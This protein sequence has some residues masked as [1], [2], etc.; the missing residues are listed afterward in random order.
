MKTPGQQSHETSLL[1]SLVKDGGH[2]GVVSIP[3]MDQLAQQQQQQQHQQT[4][5]AFS[6]SSMTSPVPSSS[7]L[8]NQSATQSQQQS[9]LDRSF[10]T[11]LIC[12][13]L[14]QLESAT[15]ISTHYQHSCDRLIKL[16]KLEC[17]LS[18]E[19][20]ALLHQRIHGASDLSISPQSLSKSS[21]SK[22]KSSSS[23]S[24]ASQ[25]NAT[26]QKKEVLAACN[27]MLEEEFNIELEDEM[28]LMKPSNEPIMNDM[29]E[30]EE[31]EE[32]ERREE[33]SPIKATREEGG[34]IIDEEGDQQIS[35][36]ANEA[37]ENDFISPLSESLLRRRAEIEDQIDAMDLQMDISVMLSINENANHFHPSPSPVQAVAQPQQADFHAANISAISSTHPDDDTY[38]GEERDNSTIA[39]NC[40]TFT[41]EP[42]HHPHVNQPVPTAVT[43]SRT[44]SSARGVLLLQEPASPLKSSPAPRVVVPEEADEP[45]AAAITIGCSP[46][47]ARSNSSSL[48]IDPYEVDAEDDEELVGILSELISTGCALHE[49]D[50]EDAVED[51]G[52]PQDDNMG[53]EEADQIIQ[54]KT[55]MND[56]EM[57]AALEFIH[58]SQEIDRDHVHDDDDHNDDGQMIK[59]RST[60]DIIQFFNNKI[61]SEF[62]RTS[63]IS[64]QSSSSFRMKAATTEEE[65]EIYQAKTPKKRGGLQEHQATSLSFS[66]PQ[67]GSELKNKTQ[68]LYS[69]KQL[70]PV[71][72]TKTGGGRGG[73][74]DENQLNYVSPQKQ[75]FHQKL[76]K[77]E[78]LTNPSLSLTAS[79]IKQKERE[80]QAAAS[81]K[82]VEIKFFG[83]QRVVVRKNSMF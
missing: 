82:N 80:A 2:G 35:P 3:S 7:Q 6:S 9:N 27:L 19:E 4:I 11:Q 62:K 61:Q 76:Q 44:S 58:P 69:L 56:Q 25:T 28:I 55:T 40:S 14:E 45:P 75:S 31:D 12:K 57:L 32:E 48:F 81:D 18:P 38:K 83:S 63:S 59:R 79:A 16:H 77:F 33:I 26:E 70:Q 29:D 17:K 37:E 8:L 46:I 65:N 30:G 36:Y 50:E 66:S 73:E 71:S 42:L 22:S 53:Q 68:S 1:F 5:A 34:V 24:G 72:S 13:Q 15:N 21:P 51:E 39:L 10:E 74:Q 67:H 47:S 52:F 41:D 60:K 20:R 64:S 78:Q 54:N 23:S 43:S 49:N